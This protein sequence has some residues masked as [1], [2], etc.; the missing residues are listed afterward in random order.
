MK[1]ENFGK[2]LSEI[3]EFM[4]MT[5]FAL[6]QRAGLTQAAISQ[7]IQGKREPTLSTVCKILNALGCSFER[8]VR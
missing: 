2:N 7:I 5:Q 3:L 4:G 8:L 1:S 6:S